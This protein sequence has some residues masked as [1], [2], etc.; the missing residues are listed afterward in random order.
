MHCDYD[1]M[2]RLLNSYG[3]KVSDQ[4]DGFEKIRW[5]DGQQAS[6]QVPWA[7][8]AARDVGKDKLKE[9]V[10]KHFLSFS[11]CASPGI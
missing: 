11:E 8:G 2:S 6:Q 3:A 9:Q 7:L 1:R 4:V 5:R 10:K